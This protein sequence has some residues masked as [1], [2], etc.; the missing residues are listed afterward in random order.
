M[1]VPCPDFM[2]LNACRTEAVDKRA[3]VKRDRCGTGG[4]HRASMLNV[5]HDLCK[6][7]PQSL[8]EV[9]VART[10]TAMAQRIRALRHRRQQ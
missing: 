10:A 8:V 1:T 3:G 6:I 7:L 2:R 9:G 4:K 5:V